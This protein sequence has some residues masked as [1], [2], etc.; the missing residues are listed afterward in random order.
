MT[1]AVTDINAFS[2]RYQRVYDADPVSTLWDSEILNPFYKN[3][4]HESNGAG[5]AY[6]FTVTT[7]GSTTTSPDYTLD[8]GSMASYQFL[9][10]PRTYHF[11]ATI[12][13]EAID[14]AKVKGS[15]ALFNAGKEQLDTAIE[16]ALQKVQLHMARDNGEVGV[17]SGVSG[18]NMT[19]PKHALA[20]VDVDTILLSA[21]TNGSGDLVGGSTTPTEEVITAINEATGELTTASAVGFTNGYT[22]WVK[23]DVYYDQNKRRSLTGAFGWLNATAAANGVDFHGQDRYDANGKL[24][25]VRMSLSGLDL[26][27]GIIALAAKARQKRIAVNIGYVPSEQ[28]N[29]LI[30]TADAREIVT[31]NTEKKAVGKTINLGSTALMVPNGNGGMME[32][33][34]WPDMPGGILML[35]NA[36]KAPFK[37]IFTDK[38]VRLHMDGGG[39]WQQVQGGVVGD[40]GETVPGLRAEGSLRLNM[41]NKCPNKWLL[42]TSWTGA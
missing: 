42:G 40:D 4:D 41:I 28:W 19:I 35:G 37:I 2:G 31:V 8:K 32:L 26:R 29:S 14:K 7:P 9:V 22:V 11:R 23:G 24:E 1:A 39:L 18:S 33:Y 21:A 12:T 16:V 25:P 15:K 30:M 20:Q 34:E 3:L 38:L 13:R 17:I 10:K 36:K 6:A 5:E 27:S